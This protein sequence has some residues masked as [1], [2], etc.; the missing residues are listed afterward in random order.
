MKRKVKIMIRLTSSPP[1]SVMVLNPYSSSDECKE[2]MQLFERY[3]VSSRYKP[4][5]RNLTK[6]QTDL[7]KKPSPQASR[8]PK[9]CSVTWGSLTPLEMSASTVCLKVSIIIKGKNEN[10][11]FSSSFGV[12][13]QE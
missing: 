8:E 12:N 11:I 9:F 1:A 5:G 4:R 3:M 13:I 6:V 2:L 10:K 7:E